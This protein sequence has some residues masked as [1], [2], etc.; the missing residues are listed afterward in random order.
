[1]LHEYLGPP[2][3]IQ[4]TT[5]RFRGLNLNFWRQNTRRRLRPPGWLGWGKKEQRRG[6]RSGRRQSVQLSRERQEE[7]SCPALLPHLASIFLPPCRRRW[8]PTPET[9]PASSI[10]NPSYSP[11]QSHRRHTTMGSFIV[12]FH[13]TFPFTSSHLRTRKPDSS[14][15]KTGTWSFGPRPVPST[16]SMKTQWFTCAS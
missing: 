14:L 12:P 2:R 4:E 16:A 10:P 9:V 8:S 5:E 6:E 1:M 7:R 13:L 3:D 11:A 15:W